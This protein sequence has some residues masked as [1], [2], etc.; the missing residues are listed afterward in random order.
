MWI[1]EVAWSSFSKNFYCSLNFMESSIS[2][3]ACAL[4]NRNDS[5]LNGEWSTNKTRGTVAVFQWRHDA[6][7]WE[8]LLFSSSIILLFI[9]SQCGHQGTILLAQ[10]DK[11]EKWSCVVLKMCHVSGV[12]FQ[13]YVNYLVNME[14]NASLQTCADVD[15]HTRVCSV[16]RKGRNEASSAKISGILFL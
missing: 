5:I 15:C 16:Q 1:Q 10:W 9:L 12:S 6:I 13:L 4:K 2:K 3:T 14:E 7:N 8:A 11:E